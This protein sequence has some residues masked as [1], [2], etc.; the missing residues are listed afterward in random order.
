MSN[1]RY[2]RNVHRDIEIDGLILSLNSSIEL[3]NSTYKM[4]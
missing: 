3:V 4:F 1:A 2:S